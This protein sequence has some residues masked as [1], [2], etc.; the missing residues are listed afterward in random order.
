MGLGQFWRGLGYN[1]KSRRL[2]EQQVTIAQLRDNIHLSDTRVDFLE[3]VLK[4]TK[5]ELRIQRHGNEQMWKF[6][7]TRHRLNQPA[8]RGSVRELLQKFDRQ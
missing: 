2:A 3:N 7:H 6:I 5:E 1:S 4:D 8:E